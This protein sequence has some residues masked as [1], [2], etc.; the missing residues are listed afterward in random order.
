MTIVLIYVIAYSAYAH[1]NS[2]KYEHLATSSSYWGSLMITIIVC[3]PILI[4]WG[5]RELPTMAWEIVQRVEPKLRKDFP[6]LMAIFT[7]II[8]MFATFALLRPHLKIANVVAFIPETNRLVFNVKNNG[9]LK[10]QNLKPELYKCTYQSNKVIEAINLDLLNISSLDWRFA[11]ADLCCLDVATRKDEAERVNKMLFNL[12]DKQCL[13]LRVSSSHIISGKNITEIKTFYKNDIMVG[14][15]KGDTLYALND[16]GA[17]VK[18]LSSEKDIMSTAHKIIVLIEVIFA[19]ILVLDLG[20]IVGGQLVN[21]HSSYVFWARCLSLLI[22]LFELARC[23]TYVPVDSSM[24]VEWS[25]TKFIQPFR[26]QAQKCELSNRNLLHFLKKGITVI[27]NK[28]EQFI[29][30]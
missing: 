25:Y 16:E 18:K 19:F 8:G 2:Y 9:L 13:E 12:D 15:F 11:H 7:T 20:W 21:Y 14:K 26:E 27:G 29:N 4:A 24:N 23:W 6:T 10:I 28:I 1:R 5:W 3:V 22:F 17:L 30:S